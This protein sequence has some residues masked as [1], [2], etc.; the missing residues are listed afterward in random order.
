MTGGAGFLGSHLVLGL[1][2]NG[3]DVTVVDD[4][5][6]GHDSNLAGVASAIRIVRADVRD[7]SA[8]GPAL[9]DVSVVFHQAACASVPRSVDNPQFVHDVN[10]TGTLAMLTAA[11]DASVSLFVYASSTAVYGDATPSPE[12]PVSEDMA[13]RP[14]S[15]YGASKLAGESYCAAFHATYGLPTIALRYFNAF[16][17]G[18]DPTSAYA[19]VIPRF[20]RALL[21]GRTPVIFGDGN[22]TRDFVYVDDVVNANLLAARAGHEAGGRA[23]NV[24]TGVSR[25]INEVAANLLDI[26]GV[27]GELEHAEPVSGEI[28]H[29]VGDVRAARGALGFTA[30]TPFR[31]GLERTVE[32]IRRR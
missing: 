25:S 30:S 17:P 31:E 27:A 22:Q 18:Q 24:A 32:A 26:V 11:R 3:Y 9:A 2:D 20:V 29:S 10:A 1:L 21:D 19:A 16:G 4:F 23:F 14:L 15:P 28:R 7:R 13:A 12:S 8:L 6:A 5:S